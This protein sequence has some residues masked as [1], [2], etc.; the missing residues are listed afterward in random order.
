M[1]SNPKCPIDGGN[2]LLFSSEGVFQCTVCYRKYSTKSDLDL[3]RA[4]F[5]AMDSMVLQAV[6][7]GLSPARILID[8]AAKHLLSGDQDPAHING[9]EFAERFQQVMEDL[10]GEV[11]E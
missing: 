10:G 2:T 1:S 7:G 8:L 9:I 3:Y 6:S 5:E 4:Y 11:P